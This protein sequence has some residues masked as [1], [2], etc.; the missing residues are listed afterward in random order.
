M[1]GGSS[2][3]SA[4]D[5]RYRQIF[6]SNGYSYCDARKL[7]KVYRS[8]PWHAKVIAGRK[9]ASGYAGRVRRQLF[10][11][12]RIF[13]RVGL[14]CGMSFNND[15]SRFMYDDAKRVADLWTSEKHSDS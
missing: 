9:I 13:R 6:F 15:P 3:A 12:M 4:N 1:F 7:G 14:R 10:R 2:A 8:S 11:G 5:Q